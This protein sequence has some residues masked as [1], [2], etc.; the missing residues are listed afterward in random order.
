M[1]LIYRNKHWLI[2]LWQYEIKEV[3]EFGEAKWVQDEL[4]EGYEI[5][6]MIVTEKLDVEPLYALH[7]ELKHNDVKGE[8]VAATGDSKRIKRIFNWLVN[9]EANQ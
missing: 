8:I 7:K 5:E 9:C 6:Q 2:Y 1:R 3:P 4:Y